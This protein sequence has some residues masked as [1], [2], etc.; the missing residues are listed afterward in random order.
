MRQAASSHYRGTENLR[1]ACTVSVDD[2]LGGELAA[3]HLVEL[4][5]ERIAYVGGPDS[6]GQVRDRRQGARNALDR[7]GLPASALVEVPTRALTVADGRAAGERI[8]GLPAARRPTAAFCANDLLALGLLQE[9]VAVDRSVP[10]DLAI[11][12]YDDIDFAA[13]A[14]VPLTSVRQPRAMLGRRAAELLLDESKNPDH[15]HQQI[16]FTPEL[17]VRA[18]T[19]TRR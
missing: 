19:V 2:I 11:V 1:Q 6:I 15:Q 14:A 10:D 17:I 7:A 12:G 13:A 5:H 8:L 9:Y 16:V 18:S 4:G 3:A